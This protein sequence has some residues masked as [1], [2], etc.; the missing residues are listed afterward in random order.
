MHFAREM[1]AYRDVRFSVVRDVELDEGVDRI[2]C[3]YDFFPVLFF[4][5]VFL[6]SDCIVILDNASGYCFSI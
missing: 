4:I 5:A 3:V 1:I 6:F 2:D